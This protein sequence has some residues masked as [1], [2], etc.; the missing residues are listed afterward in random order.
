MDMENVLIVALVAWHVALGWWPAVLAVLALEG[1]V[2]LGKELAGPGRGRSSSVSRPQVQ[3]LRSRN[4]EQELGGT[5]GG[6][7]AWRP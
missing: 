3:S 5:K 1:W 7:Q 6:A 2:G 4:R